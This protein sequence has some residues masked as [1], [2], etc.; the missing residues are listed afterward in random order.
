MFN[1]LEIFPEEIIDINDGW[2]RSC[3]LVL[4]G[5]QIK[6][7]E[8]LWWEYPKEVPKGESSDCDS[9]LL[10]TFLLAMKYRADLYVHGTISHELLSNITELQKIWA[11]CAPDIYREVSIE[12]DQINYDPKKIDKAI[13]AFSG[14]VDAQFSAYRHSKHLASYVT[15][16]LC[17]GVFIHGFDI[18]LSDKDGFKLAAEKAKITLK[19]INLDLI[20]VRTNIREVVSVNWEHYFAAALASV[21]IGMKK[22]AGIGLI[23]SS[24]PYDALILPW[25]SHPMTD[26]LLSSQNFRIIHDGAGYSRSE[27]LKVLTG[28]KV[29][30][31]NLRVCWV[32]NLTYKNCGKCEKC[33]RTRLNLLTAGINN[34]GCFEGSLDTNVLKKIV[35]TND[36]VRGEWRLIVKEILKTGNGIELLKDV[37]EVINRPSVKWSKL[38]PVGSIRREWVKNFLG[39]NK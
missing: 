17:Y 23:A 3:T 15:Q 6:K 28:W 22:I 11:K 30:L 2:K 9:Y 39:K 31:D 25:G 36:A 4:T 34:P 32:G 13:V 7:Q 37:E 24:E 38:L 19:D 14:G 18:K 27:K 33:V 5:D 29:G 1:K 35:L 21:L 16:P 10:S 12:V 26:P 8:T 20:K